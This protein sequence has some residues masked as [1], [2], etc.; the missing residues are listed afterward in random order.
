MK[1][2]SLS[3]FCLQHHDGRI[4]VWRHR[5]ERMLNSCVMRRHTGL[6]PGIM[7]AAGKLI[8]FLQDGIQSMDF[9]EYVRYF[10]NYM[11][12]EDKLN[13]EENRKIAIFL[14]SVGAEAQRQ[15]Y[16]LPKASTVTSLSEAID[17][18]RQRYVV[19]SRPWVIRMKFNDRRQLQG[20]TIADYISALRALAKE[21]AHGS[22]EDELI[23]DRFIVGTKIKQLR[24]RLL[25]ET[26]DLNLDQVVQLA[27]Q[28]EKAQEDNKMFDKTPEGINK[29]AANDSRT[30]P[31]LR[32]RK[33]ISTNFKCLRCGGKHKATSPECP[34]K[35]V[36]CHQCLKVGHFKKY[37]LS[38][39]SVKNI[40][41]A[42]GN[43]PIHQPSK[44]EMDLNVNG[45]TSNVLIKFLV[46]TGSSVSLIP[47]SLYTKYFEKS[48]LNPASVALKSYTQQAIDVLGDLPAKIKHGNTVVHTL[49]HVVRADSP[50]LGLELFNK[51]GLSIKDGKVNQITESSKILFAKDIEYKIFVD[52]S[53]PPVQQKLRRLPP[54]LL[55]EVHR[56]IQ[57]LVKMDMI[58]PIVTSKWISPIVVSKKKDGSIRLCID[59]REPNK[60]V[61][62]DA[63]PI[64]LIEDI[65]SSLH[66][67]KVFTNLDLS[68][69][70]HQ[71]RLHPDS[72]YLTAFITH[73]EIYQ[74]KRLPYGLSSAPGA[75]QRYLSEL[76]MDIKG[77]SCYLDDIII[78]GSSMED[79]D[80]KLN[81]V[82]SR[83]REVNLILNDVKSIYRQKSLKFL[84]HIIDDN[85]VHL[86]E[87]LMKPL[88]DAPPPK[89]KSGLR[90]LIGM[91]NWFQKY[92]PNKIKDSLKK[93]Q[94]LALF[95]P[96]LPTVITTDASHSGI[97]CVVSQLSE[98]G[99]E[100]I[101]ACASRTLSDAERKYSIVE[102]EALACVWACEKF[103]RWV[104][105]LK[106]TL[107][108]DQYSLTT[109]LTTKGNDRAG[110]RIARWSARLMNFDY[111]IEYKKGRDNVL[112][113]YLSRSSLSSYEDHDGEVELIASINQDM[114]AI[115]E[116]EFLR[117]GSQC[118]EIIALK[119][120]LMK[121]W[122]NN[123]SSQLNKYFRLRKDLSVQEDLILN[124]KGKILVPVSLRNKLLSFAHKAHQGMV[125]TK[126]R[127][128]ES[129]WWP[130]MDKDVEDLVTNF[131]VCKNH[132]KRLKSIR[133]PIT[134]VERPANPWT[135]LGLDIVGPF[136]DTEI[137]FRFAITLIDY[138]SKWPEVFCTNKTTSKV[139]INFLEDVF[140]REGFPRDEELARQAVPAGGL[141]ARKV[142]DGV[143][144][145][146]GADVWPVERVLLTQLAGGGGGR[147]AGDEGSSRSWIAGGTGEAGLEGRERPP[148][149]LWALN[150]V[151]LLV[152]DDADR[153]T[154]ADG[155]CQ[156]RQRWVVCPD[157]GG[158]ELRRDVTSR[159]V[160]VAVAG[161]V[162]RVVQG[163]GLRQ[164]PRLDGGPPLPE[165]PVVVIVRCVFLQLPDVASQMIESKARA[166]HRGQ[167]RLGGG[168]D[169]GGGRAHLEQHEAVVRE[170]VVAG[171]VDG[172]AIQDSSRDEDPVQ[173]VRFDLVSVHGDSGG[174]EDNGFHLKI[175]LLNI[176]GSNPIS[177]EF[178]ELFKE[179][180]DAYNG[181]LIHI[182]L[183]ENAV[184][185]FVKARAVPFALREL[186][187]KKLKS[188]EEKGII[189]PIKFSK[190]ASPI[191]T[192]LKNDGTIRICHD[193]KTTVNLYTNPDKYPLPTIPQLLDRLRGGKVFTKLDMAQAYQQLKV[194][195]ES[196]EILTINT[197]RGLYRVKRLPFGLNSAVGTFQRFMD[198]LLMGI[199][200]V[201]VYL[202]DVL[203]SGINCGDLLKKTEKVI[204]RFKE[205]GL[206]LKRNKCKFYVPEIEFLGMKIDNKG[207]HPSEEKL[208]TIKDARPPSNKKEL[209][210]FL[211]LLNYYERFLRNKATVVEPLHRLLDSN[212]PWK[213]NREHQ[214]ALKEAKSL[215][216]SESVLAHFDD[217]LP[218]LV[219]CDASEY[220]I[221]AILFQVDHGVERQV[222]FASRTLNKTERRY[223][224]IDREALA[225]IFAVSKF[226]QYL[227]GR[228]F[229]ILT[230]HKPLIGLFNPSKPI[231]Q[232]LSPRMLRWCLTLSAYSYSIEYKPGRTNGNVD[233][234]SR[235][236]LNESPSEVP[237]PPEVFFIESENAAVSSSEVAKLTNKD[238]I[239]PRIK[240][241][242]MNGWPEQRYE[243]KFK[244]FSNRSSEISVHKDCLLWGSRVIIPEKLRRD[245]LNLL[246]D[247]NIGIV[248]TK[249]LARGLCWW[250]GMDKDIERMIS[251]CAVCLSCSHDP[252]KTDVYP[253]IWPSRPWSRL[254]IDHAG[255]FQGKLFLVVVDA[256]SKWIEAKIVSTT[257]TETTINSLRELFATHG[258]AD[259]IV[260]DNGTSFTSELFKTFLK[261]NG[262]RHILCAPYHAAS[263]GQVER[264]IQTL[265][266]LLRKNSSGNWTTRLSRSLLSMR[267]AINSTT[268]KS[269]AQLLLNRN[270][271][272]LLN[273][274]HPEGVSEGRMRQ[275]DRFI[276]N[277]KPHRVVNEGQA[278]IARGY[279]GPRWIPGVVQEKTGI[280][281]IKVE[282]DDGE[283]LNRHLYQVRGCGESEATPST[284]STPQESTKIE[285][286]QAGQ[287]ID[288]TGVA[289]SPILRRSS[290]LR[291]PSKFF[292]IKLNEIIAPDVHPLPLIE[293][294]L[295]K[296]SKAKYYSSVDIASAYWQVEIEP[297]S[298]NL[299]AFVTLDSQYEFCRLPYG[300]QNS[301]QIY[302]RAINQVMQKY[303]LNF[304][305]HYFDDFIIF[306]DTLEDHLQHLQQFLTV[307]QH[308][309]I[310]LNY[311]KCSFFKTNIDFLGY[312]V[313]AGTYAP[314]TR[315][316]DT[317]NAIKPPTNQKTLQ[318][319]LGAVNVY[320]KF[321]ADYAR[322]RTPLNKLLKKDV[323]WNWDQDCQ[324]AFT[325][326]KES[327]TSKPVLHLYQVGSPCRLYC[328]ASTQGIAGILKQVHP[329]G[330][331][332]PV[333]Y[334][335][336]AL[337]AHERNYTVSELECLAIV[338]SVDK[339]RIYLTGFI[340]ADIIKQ[341]QPTQHTASTFNIDTNGLHTITRKGVT[342]IIIPETLQNTLM[343]KVHQEYNHP[344]I[345]QMTRIITTQYYWK[346][347][348]KSIEKFV[349]SCHTCQII[350]RP[351]GKPYGALGQIPPPQQPFDLISIDTIAGFSKYGHSKTYL[352]V[353]VNHLTRYAWT[354]PSKST[355]TLTYIQTLKTV[356]QQ[357][358]PKRLLSDRAPA[359]TSEKFRKFLITHGIQP[360]LTTS[361]NPQ[362]NG[363]IERLNATITGKLRLAYLENLKASWTQL[364]K[365]VTQT[366]NNTPHSVT[367]FPPTY[368]MLNVVPPDLRTH[369]NPYPEITRA[370][371]IARSRTQNKHK[372]DKETF[373]KQHRTPHFEVNDLVLVKNYRHPDT[374]KLVP[375]FTGPYKIIEI[376][377]PNVVRIDRPNQPLNRDS[378]TIHVNKLKYYTEN[379]LYITPPHTRYVQKEQRMS[380]DV[381]LSEFKH[382]TPDIFE[383]QLYRI[384]PPQT[385]QPFL[386]LNP[387]LFNSDRFKTNL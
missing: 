313:T 167:A 104:W 139:I 82:L 365:R 379:V 190:W 266:N 268:Q 325:T 316:L 312:T 215:I 197:P 173:A 315:N 261:R 124:E 350:K 40:T 116:E 91:I 242:A 333:Q 14:N 23:R 44:L 263:N 57:R 208:R 74:F 21:C 126:Q 35:D 117:G 32:E 339:F 146:A 282:T 186:V 335:S 134:P 133:V 251:S 111:N 83:L 201:A 26:T 153:A 234:L 63:Y 163:S 228:K 283:I 345:S 122:S 177:L 90:S 327:L 62:L 66:G 182:D 331:V 302:H 178:E 213:W 189:E 289:S 191:V 373:D 199:D 54:V 369:L 100:R 287:E 279:H 64:P 264:A 109:L 185:K 349:R 275:E 362:A 308:E 278:V 29:I 176:N 332:H 192:V 305:T 200:G 147:A 174:Q 348:S 141:S 60:A 181:P 226:Y 87:E 243:E 51:L 259:V 310:T 7:M 257:S 337:R 386:H 107:R 238:P 53:V 370:R 358:F 180:I 322:L 161:S 344:G 229:K 105:G 165:G 360:L 326:L 371:E 236:P 299:L 368:L 56:E 281:Y 155:A 202:D 340:S 154:E 123:E 280:V 241:W 37:C 52:T 157:G 89:D 61:I 254:H 38:K 224:V 6:A 183:P 160:D 149:K 50:I 367:S 288:P 298:R 329:D 72:R 248:E 114:L 233:A 11:I 81:Q 10:N 237:N 293:T 34:A 113:D 256:Y 136:I 39:F 19:K 42:Q 277:W 4:R 255:P 80:K 297:N 43:Q 172:R 168:G 103:R 110:L 295:D 211:G 120:Q 354:F 240:F 353:I 164:Q 128:R 98:K 265:K 262:V 95:C 300:F 138:T 121:P 162:A 351:K 151:V 352:H 346:G 219:S 338:E 372:K 342:K 33:K 204:L 328:D 130:G 1:L 314:Q 24:D 20:E 125:R 323:K 276:R 9:D 334:F 73:M 27:T 223:A 239:L 218:I 306:S 118:L 145:L 245:I 159:L 137:G 320:N 75:F 230:D 385:S 13:V 206:G 48:K 286:P 274:F 65:L 144:Y 25:V 380:P 375:Y 301:P 303:K 58:E 366:Y 99:E 71:I 296:L 291:R 292:E 96:N 15:Y 207:I 69:A 330:Q 205:A 384:I 210:S 221:G 246:H 36:K 156:V 92:I 67:C 93:G 97:G 86:D 59:L 17:L 217:N 115:S 284:S 382:L 209:M 101:V 188:L 78:G 270:L 290:R 355:S 194:D 16:T 30:E 152:P 203:I 170:V 271:K 381:Y 269:P 106:F 3:G 49:L 171:L 84:G 158:L 212:N 193:Y 196:S 383:T 231:P 94:V 387:D 247:T 359:F 2:S 307:C 294:I 319:F 273:K 132:D 175:N 318:S 150:D 222:V 142:L 235:L 179:E 347:I 220:G 55:D 336:R 260:S 140:S 361:H 47:E 76:L 195:D 46:D 374:G 324:Q 45:G 252:P 18:L 309:N 70:Y 285:D 28:Y 225:V 253:W 258:L 135:K 143:G 356:L 148:P 311:N 31:N 357:G 216:S 41:M 227:L 5:G 129:Y 187:D 68:Q 108:T 377:S 131:W 127:L 12:A 8:P 198:T 272:S 317:I 250:P 249:A 244:D 88:L 267:I 321:I 304:V 184:P 341:H 166:E 85:G 112:P 214:R 22:M 376:I 364:V 378:D 102:K 363:L 119:E 79:H 232:V 169:G 77:V 343:N